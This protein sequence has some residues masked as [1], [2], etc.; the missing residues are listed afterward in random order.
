MKKYL[1]SI[2]F[3]AM[4]LVMP[5]AAADLFPVDSISPDGYTSWGYMAEDGSQAIPY[6]YASASA[7]TEDG[8]AAVTNSSGSLAVIDETG[9]QIVPFRSA[10]AAVEYNETTIAFRYG[11]QTIFFDKTGS[12]LGAFAG[13]DGFFSAEGL[14]AVQ[15]NGLWG[16]VNRQNETVIAPQYRAA[17]AFSDGFAV[18]QRTDLSYAVIDAAGHETALPASGA[19]KYMEVYGGKLVVMDNGSR[20]AVFSLETGALLSDYLYQE[21]SPYRDGYAM[22]RL[23]NR[24]GIVNLNG[25]TTLPFSYNYLSYM[26]EGVY[27]A[28]GDD[29]Y[30]SALDAEGNLV[31]RTDVYAG[32]FEAIEHGV[33]WH[34]TMDNGIIFFSRV[35]GYITKLANAENPTVLTDNVV[36]VTI[37]GKRQY[38]RLSD[39]KALYSP[40]REYDMQ[41]FKVTTTSYEKYLGMKNGQEYGWSLTY[42][43]ISGLADKTVQSTIN[44]AIETFF[45]EGPS[46]SAQREALTGSYG[47]RVKGRLLIVW[48]DCV[49]GIGEGASV[50]NDCITLDLVTGARYSLVRDLFTKDYVDTVTDYLPDGVP[51]YLFAYPRITDTGISFFL[52]TAQTAAQRAPS[53][54]E[55]T[56]PFARL[57]GAINTDSE[58]WRA[59]NGAAMGALNSYSGYTDVPERHWAYNAIRTVT[60]ADLMHGDGSQFR[61]DEAITTAEVAAVMIRALGIDTSAIAPLDGAPWY[62]IETTAAAKAGLTAG[63]DAPIDYTAAMTRADAMQVLANTLQKDG[64]TALSEAEITVCL[65]RFRDGA[66]VPQ[67]R[68]A[69]AALCVRTGAIVGSDGKLD[70]NGVFTRAQ[71]AQILSG[72]LAMTDK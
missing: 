55:Y 48:A 12:L 65:S 41:Y 29:G 60:E 13:A 15:R 72:L 71:F 9:R 58:C 36:L 62:Y 19:P 11:D 51:Y 3:A 28:R 69:A 54:Q 59:L 52:N 4:A 18:V 26:G 56:I 31:Y 42:P 32:G 25:S 7:F 49:S 46:F 50:W 64:A 44:S 14:L 47:L 17:G 10:P 40:E 39:N 70:A 16:Y 1:L 38:V 2:F 63:L 5:A 24:W 53:S 35:G 37:A 34:G 66:A 21:I 33:S 20:S 30:V 61:P 27:A 8:L 23:N 67:N 68:R 45:L 57:S 43:V 22:M 6:Q